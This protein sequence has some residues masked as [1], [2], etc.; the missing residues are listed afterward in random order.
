MTNVPKTMEAYSKLPP[1]ALNI[2]LPGIEFS[3][4]RATG[5]LEFTCTNPETLATLLMDLLGEVRWDSKGDY[6]YRDGTHAKFVKCRQAW[7]FT[8]DK[9]LIAAFILMK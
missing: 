9:K 3:R 1:A 2:E 4:K 6:I 8:K 7:E 5:C